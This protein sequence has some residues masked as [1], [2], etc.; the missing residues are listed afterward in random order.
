MVKS[1]TFDILGGATETTEHWL[2]DLREEFGWVS[3]RGAFLCLRSTLHAL[4]DQMSVRDAAK[5]GDALPV[6]IRGVFYEG[7]NP[8]AVPVQFV[9][10]EAFLTR[11]RLGCRVE[12][13]PDPE[14]A[15]RAV[16][17]V[18]SRRVDAD[19]IK[20]LK[21]GLPPEIRKLWP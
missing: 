17:S 19:E 9:D 11:I 21:A 15:A 4:R 6:L 2:A 18:L 8:S 12:P 3:E 16:F 5:L 7:W 1:T 20:T 13:G 10:R 14:H